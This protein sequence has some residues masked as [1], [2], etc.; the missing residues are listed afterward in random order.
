MILMVENLWLL[1][2]DL[3]LLQTFNMKNF[4]KQILRSI[5]KENLLSQQ[6]DF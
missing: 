6:Q 4:K 3:N 5:Y 1:I 2:I